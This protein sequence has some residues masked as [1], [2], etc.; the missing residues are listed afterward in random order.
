MKRY[1]LRENIPEKVA[2]DLARYSEL[3]QKLLFYR[4]ISDA[5][6]ADKFFKPDFERDLHDPFLLP[7]M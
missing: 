1:E 3:V 2:Q 7:N 6:T 5:E 4:G